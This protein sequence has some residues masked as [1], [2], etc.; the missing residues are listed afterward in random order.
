MATATTN[1]PAGSVEY[2]CRG[3]RAT[4][5]FEDANAAKR[6]YATK[7]KA[8]KNPKVVNPEAPP[9]KAKAT[10]QDTTTP[11]KQAKPEAKPVDKPTNP[12]GVRKCR[13]KGYLAGLLVMRHGLDAGMTDAMVAELDELTG[14]PSP[15]QSRFDLAFAWHA[16][17][18]WQDLDG[19]AA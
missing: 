10:K 15:G 14:K 16:V 11:A 4:K 7:D 3:K 6:F 2:D 9:K 13:S 12:P 8:G 18:G 5:E 17:R 1:K 19:E